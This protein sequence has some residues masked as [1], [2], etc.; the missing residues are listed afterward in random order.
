ML[1]SPTKHRARPPAV[2]N[3]KSSVKSVDSTGSEPVYV[4]IPEPD[5]SPPSSPEFDRTKPGKP[6]QIMEFRSK[7]SQSSGVYKQEIVPAL[8]DSMSRQDSGIYQKVIRGGS[9]QRQDNQVKKSNDYNKPA[10]AVDVMPKFN[11]MPKLRKVNSADKSN[12]KD[13]TSPVQ[14]SAHTNGEQ[15]TVKQ[16]QANMENLYQNDKISG[17]ENEPVSPRGISKFPP[18]APSAPRKDNHKQIYFNDVPSDDSMPTPHSPKKAPAPP[19]PVPVIP[20]PPPPIQSPGGKGRLKQIHW[21][22]IPKP[23]VS[24]I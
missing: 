2:G 13:K 11:E 15:L 24:I 6:Q 21:N 8:D 18:P 9:V 7:P 3:L 1:L 16:I 10:G 12:E 4:D 22:R 5:Y 19:P 14:N 23:L 17:K 20:A